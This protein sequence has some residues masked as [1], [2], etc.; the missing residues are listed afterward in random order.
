MI[1][2]QNKISDFIDDV[3]SENVVR[4]LETNLKYILGVKVSE[5]EKKSWEKSL[6]EL[7]LIL[8][9]KSI[10][11]NLIIALEYQIPLTSKRIDAFIL[12][13]EGLLI[14]LKQWEK[15]KA[16]NID[17]VVETFIG[18]K[19]R[20]TIHPSYQAYSYYRFLFDFNEFVRKN[21]EIKPVVFMHNMEKNDDIIKNYKE[22]TSKAP[23]F[24][25]EDKKKLIRLIS[26]LNPPKDNILEKIEN[27]SVCPSKQLVDAVN[28]MLKGNEE[29]VLLDFQKI[30]F[31]KSKRL[32]NGVYIIKGAPGS[33]K[34]VLA[35]NLLAEFLSQNKN[36]RYVTKNAAIRE[37]LIE[38]L[39][40]DYKKSYLKNL[41]VSS[42]SF[43]S[44]LKDEFDVLIVDE[45]HRLN[46]KSGLFSNK[47]E[48]Q[49]KEII[50]SSKLAIF[51]IDEDQ[52]V[53]FK[54][55]GEVD[56]IKYFAKE[57]GKEIFEDELDTQFRCNGADGYLEWL[58][59]V[60]EIR[61]NDKYYLKSSEFDFRV[62]DDITE[63]ENN[64]KGKNSAIVAGYCWD[65]ISKKEDKYDI[66]IGEFKKKWNLED[67]GSLWILKNPLN[68]VGCIHTIQGLETDYIG[69]IIGE[70]LKYEDGI[71]TYPENRARTD[72]S[73]MGFKKLYKENKHLA[74][75]KADKIIKNTYRVLM[76]RGKKG[77]FVYCMDKKLGE[78]LKSRIIKD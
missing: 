27:S 70:D 21:Y 59:N 35:I 47:G 13:E 78:Y 51:F 74:L 64:L 22:Y 17:A 36:V 4:L 18:K 69:V 42:G 77:C 52:I 73:L 26:S 32:K 56:T 45:A 38:K 39:A 1:V 50:Y 75:E 49:I 53:T 48:N 23:I 60:L 40:S 34:S 46:E 54:D 24:F 71:V 25:K 14:E 58:D 55:I 29:F 31:E 16:T 65:W 2:Y 28:L 7:A 12:G 11:K 72:K 20:E 6:K 33:G 8:S 41:F 63:M 19:I 57:L 76:T 5:S 67:D 44:T 62:F 9:D 3:I 68:Q 15:V 10:D 66:E 61:K 43:T 30:I 37:V